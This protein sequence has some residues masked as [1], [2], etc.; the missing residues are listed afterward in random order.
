VVT[1]RVQPDRFF[2][3]DGLDLIAEVPIN[4][5]QATLGS[6]VSVASLSGDKVAVKVPPGTP[7]GK[8]F[9]VPG[10]GITKDGQTGALVVEVRIVAPEELSAEQRTAMER[11]AEVAGLK[12]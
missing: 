5:A 3:R 2:T 12:Y 6:K 11:F 7:S 1:F 8:R 4:I 10:Q 9:R